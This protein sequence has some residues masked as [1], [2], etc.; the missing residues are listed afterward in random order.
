MNDVLRI[1]AQDGVLDGNALGK[2]Q[3]QMAGGTAL[4]D[5]LRAAFH[6]S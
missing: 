3:E 6:T 2:V 4:E 5:A 1:L